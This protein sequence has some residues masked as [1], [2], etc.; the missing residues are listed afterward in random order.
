MHIQYS[1]NGHHEIVQPGRVSQDETLFISQFVKVGQFWR[2]CIFSQYI[3]EKV[4][5]VSTIAHVNEM[6]FK[7]INSYY[8]ATLDVVKTV[9]LGE[10]CP[11]LQVFLKEGTLMKLS[12]KVMQPRMFFLV[13]DKLI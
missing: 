4:W 9:H 6:F 1:L 12:R 10:M 13:S 11:C 2:G 7:V 5:C 3:T 8:W